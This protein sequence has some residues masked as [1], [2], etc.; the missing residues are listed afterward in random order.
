MFYNVGQ[1]LSFIIVKA[2]CVHKILKMFLIERMTN[3]DYKTAFRV[4]ALLLGDYQVHEPVWVS[5]NLQLC[6]ISYYS[7]SQTC[8]KFYFLTCMQSLIYSIEVENIF[9]NNV[10]SLP[11]TYFFQ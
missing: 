3:K 11:F 5:G 7:D 9:C 1:N 6:S 10:K 4:P 2:D 8:I